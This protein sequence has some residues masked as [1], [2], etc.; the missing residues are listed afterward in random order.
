LTDHGQNDVCSFWMRRRRWQPCTSLVTPWLYK[1]SNPQPKLVLILPTSEGWKPESSYLPG[2]GVEPLQSWL[3]MHLSRCVNQLSK[4]G[5]WSSA[6]I[7]WLT[8]VQIVKLDRISTGSSLGRRL[9]CDLIFLENK[10]IFP[11]TMISLHFPRQHCSYRCGEVR[12]RLTSV[13]WVLHWNL[14]YVLPHIVIA[15]H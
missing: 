4:P 6:E 13:C 12:W 5:R 10:P 11:H 8:N 14:K 15:I 9:S 1:D 2:S 3:N 7:Q